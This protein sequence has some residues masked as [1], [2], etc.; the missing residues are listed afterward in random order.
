L[1]FSGSLSD[2]LGRSPQFK[3][4]RHNLGVGTHERELRAIRGDEHVVTRAIRKSEGACAIGLDAIR[5]G[6]RLVT[7]DLPVKVS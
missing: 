4:R 2:S 1:C 5:L 6:E 3:T 7:S